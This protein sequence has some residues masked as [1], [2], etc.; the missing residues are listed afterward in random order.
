MSVIIHSDQS[1]QKLSKDTKNHLFSPLAIE[2]IFQ[3]EQSLQEDSGLFKDQL[4]NKTSNKLT[5]LVHDAATYIVG[6]NEQVPLFNF[7]GQRDSRL[8]KL[9]HHTLIL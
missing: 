4:D 2:L 3:Q 9:T 8:K 7:I 1:T 6:D 5:E